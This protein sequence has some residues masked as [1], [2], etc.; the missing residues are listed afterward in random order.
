MRD[1]LL[2][3]SGGFLGAV[4][5]Y[6]VNRLFEA[7][8]IGAQFPL[9]TFVVNVSGCFAIGI[10]AGLGERTALLAPGPRLF[11]MTG[12]LGGYTTFSAFALETLGLGRASASLPMAINVLGQ[13]GLGMLAVF[14]GY[15]IAAGAAA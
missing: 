15:R 14:V 7:T 8:A 4:A 1:V 2:V 5:R 10:L 13:I 6:G 9:G 12:V 3:G 11:L